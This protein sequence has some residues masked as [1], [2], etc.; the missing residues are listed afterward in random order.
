MRSVLRVVPPPPPAHWGFPL[1]TC[2]PLATQARGSEQFL[3]PLALRRVR[4]YPPLHSH[5]RRGGVFPVRR[6]MTSGIIFACL[7]CADA[8]VFI[9]L[10][11]MSIPGD[12]KRLYLGEAYLA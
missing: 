9:V 3:L 4:C 7:C 12:D 11:W 10:E 1:P 2:F 5:R 8:A 6:P